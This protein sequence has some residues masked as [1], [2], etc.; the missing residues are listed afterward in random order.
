MTWE[1]VGQERA[2]AALRRAVADEARLSHA[3]LFAGPERVGKA[4]AARRFAQAMNC[5]AAV[6][7]DVERPCGECRTCRLIE[8]GKHADVEVV[9]VGGLCDESEHGDHSADN[10]RD[11]RIC[12]VR[13]L[14]HVV[15]R[16]PYEGRYRVIVIDPAD[17]MTK[18][19]A[20]A[21]LKTLEEPAASVVLVLVTSREAALAETVRSR[22]RRIEFAGVPRAEIESALVERWQ[23]EPAVAARL[24]RLAEGRLG[25]AVSAVTDDSVL[26]ARE[27][28]FDEIETLLA[29]GDE[30]RFAYAAALGRRYPRESAA[31]Q[32][33]LSHWSA[34]WREVLLA[35]GG[36]PEL[37]A[38]TERLD[39][40][41]SYAQQYGVAGALRALH[42]VEDA[43]RHLDEHASPTLALEV[44]LLELPRVAARRAG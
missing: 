43:R 2:L 20:N 17:A 15:S 21:F 33:N 9:S 41:R 31:V 30:E 24:A 28:A 32:A 25:W 18:D 35:A 29:G 39:R 38:E 6:E 10:S 8:E 16:A 42:A 14:G 7:D 12:Q 5:E 44:M 36:Q 40:L 22:C 27:E 4:T 23:A 34:W 3:Y 19:A 37:A 26:A 1:I 11:I 13:R